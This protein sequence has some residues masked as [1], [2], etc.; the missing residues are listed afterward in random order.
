MHAKHNFL[1]DAKRGTPYVVC[2]FRKD[3]QL[4]STIISHFF[5]FF[6]PVT[7]G[8]PSR[9]V[10]RFAFKVCLQGLSSR[11]PSKFAFKVCLSSFAFNVYL[12]AFVFRLSSRL[13]LSTNLDDPGAAL[14][15]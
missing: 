9:F 12:P 8:L 11:L 10:F 14:S 7:N 4:L 1:E 13:T 2:L 6:A 15:S 5:A 3:G